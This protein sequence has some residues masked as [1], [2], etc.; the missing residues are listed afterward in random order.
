MRYIHV[1][2]YCFVTHA[3]I[4][5]YSRLACIDPEVKGQG[6]TVTKTVTVARTV[7]SGHVPYSAYHQYAAVLP[8]AVAG[9]CLH[10]YTTA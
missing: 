3:G 7:A 9:E 2:A 5:V 6:H 10:V 8:A 1:V 4:G